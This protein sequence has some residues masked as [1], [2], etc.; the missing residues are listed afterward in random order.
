MTEVRMQDSACTL[1]LIEP[2]AR[3]APNVLFQRT[4]R[5]PQENKSELSLV[6]MLTTGLHEISGSQP[7]LLKKVITNQGLYIVYR[8]KQMP[9]SKT[10][11]HTQVVTDIQHFANFTDCLNQSNHKGYYNHVFCTI[12]FFISQF[13]PVYSHTNPLRNLLRRAAMRET[14]LNQNDANDNFK[15]RYDNTA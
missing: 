5:R 15:V 14:W 3:T 2:N 13:R 12:W 8:C 6:W 11:R 10:S 1:S 9:G 4:Q 7:S